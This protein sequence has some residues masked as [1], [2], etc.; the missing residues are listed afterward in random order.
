V[1][2]RAKIAAYVLLLIGVGLA[3]ALMLHFGVHD[4]AAVVASCG[5]GVFWVFAWRLV[6][7]SCDA[8]GWLRL[9]VRAWNPPLWR[10]VWFRWIGEA[11]NTLLPVAQIGG[12]LVRAR[13]AMK[14]GARGAITA[15]SSV[16]D[17]ILALAAQAILGMVA[18]GLLLSK[19]GFSDLTAALLLTG[20]AVVGGIVVLYFIPRTGFIHFVIRVAAQTFDSPRMHL[21]NGGADRMQQEILDLYRRWP[22]MAVSLFWRIL[23]AVLRVGETWM[24]LHLMGVDMSFEYALII[25]SLTNLM[26]TA[27]FAVPGGLGLQEGGILLFGHLLGLGPDEALALALVKRMREIV[28]GV[29]AVLGWTWMETKHFRFRRPVPVPVEVEEPGLAEAY[30]PSTGR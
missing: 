24:I 25:E 15:A 6:P 13:L 3:L 17:I 18:V 1:K 10:A 16:F 4:V 11:V 14:S 23:A 27:A 22:D 8:V 29:P 12:D 30:P 20:I 21:V 9:Y 19:T 5:W 7:I 28:V 26:R 2:R